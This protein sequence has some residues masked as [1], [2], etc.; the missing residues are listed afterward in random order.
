M[1]ILRSKRKGMMNTGVLRPV[2]NPHPRHRTLLPAVSS[3]GNTHLL[4]AWGRGRET[5]RTDFLEK[6]L[7]TVSAVDS[8]WAA[9]GTFL[10]KRLSEVVLSSRFLTFRA[11]FP[12]WLL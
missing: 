6:C 5:G 9:K 10:R 12:L 3:L 2:S 8:L 4:L 1:H 11:A 7:K